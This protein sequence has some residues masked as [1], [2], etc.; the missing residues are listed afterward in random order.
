M[1]ALHPFIY[2]LDCNKVQGLIENMDEHTLERTYDRRNDG[3]VPQ[4][5]PVSSPMVASYANSSEKETK[6][7]CSSS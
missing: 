1:E 6:G 7:E 3:E 5:D 4:F 2:E